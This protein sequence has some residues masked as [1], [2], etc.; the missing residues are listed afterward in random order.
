MNK[1][2]FPLLSLL[3]CIAW[4]CKETKTHPEV[5]QYAAELMTSGSLGEDISLLSVDD[6]WLVFTINRND[7]TNDAGVD[8]TVLKQRFMSSLQ[9]EKQSPFYHML[10]LLVKEEMGIRVV[11]H[12]GVFDSKFDIEIAPSEVKWLY[13]HPLTEHQV[14]LK[15]VEA[16]VALL[17]QDMPKVDEAT[18]LHGLTLM[19]DTLVYFYTLEP[20]YAQDLITLRDA[21]PDDEIHL[22]VARDFLLNLN[23]VLAPYNIKYKVYVCDENGIEILNEQ[24]TQAEVTALFAAQTDSV[25]AQTAI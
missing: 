24:Y 2:I 25:E 7:S 23:D 8:T 11:Q 1:Y 3:L 10:E 12:E 15:E 22:Y 14:D 19:T 13:D 16:Y 6:D 4:S 17:N 5:E 20:K 9:V 18:T 21:T